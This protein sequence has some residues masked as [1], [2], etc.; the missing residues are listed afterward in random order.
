MS[1]IPFQQPG[2]LIAGQ[3]AQ[4]VGPVSASLVTRFAPSVN[5]APVGADL[6]LRVQNEPGASPASFIDATIPAG[7]FVATPNTGAL[8]I[9]AGGT[10]WIRVVSGPIGDDVA[11]FLYGYVENNLADPPSSTFATLSQVK[12]QGKLVTAEA[13]TE[14]PIII[15]AVTLAM[16]K[17]MGRQII[18]ATYTNERHSVFIETEKLYTSEWPI[19]S[20]SAVEVDGSVVDPGEYELVQPAGDRPGYLYCFGLWQPSRSRTLLTYT[21]GYS[22]TPS[23]LVQACV[24]QTLYLFMQGAQGGA[25]LGEK[26]RADGG[27]GST[28]YITDD[29]LADVKRVLDQY[30]RIC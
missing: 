1:T 13:D 3:E 11:S 12:A 24:R 4:I 19:S 27:G 22:A 6:V 2:D 28:L 7:S 14:L 16:Q 17:Y 8:A 15:Q 23:D 5:V 9:G 18:E 29:W 30:R 25:R 20:V 26:S 10:I 21:A